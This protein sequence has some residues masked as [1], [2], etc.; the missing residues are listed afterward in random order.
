MIFEVCVD[1]LETAIVADQLGCNR[2]E[3]CCALTVGG[4][5][6][7]FGLIKACAEHTN[8]E[9]H[10]MIRHQEG[11]FTN[12]DADIEIMKADIL[13]AHHAGAKGVVFGCLTANHHID[14]DKTKELINVAKSVG[15]AITFHRAFD[16][17]AD[18]FLAIDQLI[19]LGVG[20]VLTS[21]QENTAIEGAELI[22]QLVS[23]SDNRIEIMA[24]SGVN[25]QNA[26]KLAGTGVNA[27]HFTANITSTIAPLLGMGSKTIPNRQKIESIIN[28][29]K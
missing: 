12:S 22:K 20:R 24:G 14:N 29:L 13:M 7:S 21:G 26:L 23:Y 27:L 5:T 16:F 17:V 25:S 1:N 2:I 18:P 8:L 15:L 4:L 10:V 3:L 6:P 9:V 19:H 28:A 11:G